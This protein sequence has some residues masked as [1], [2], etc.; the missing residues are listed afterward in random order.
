M[1]A[2]FPPAGKQADPSR[3]GC[4]ASSHLVYATHYT[5]CRLHPLARIWYTLCSY[6]VYSINY[7]CRLQ[8]VLVGP[9][10]LAAAT[11]LLVSFEFTLGAAEVPCTL[12]FIDYTCTVYFEFTLGA[13]EVGRL[14]PAAVSA[15]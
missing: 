3:A 15:A 10:P 12:Y 2:V 14:R 4:T 8:R 6:V 7:T 5:L 11:E 13:A 9:W 1:T